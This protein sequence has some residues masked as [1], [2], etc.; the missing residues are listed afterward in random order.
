MEHM[1]NTRGTCMEYHWNTSGM[2]MEYH[3]S[4]Q[5]MYGVNV[6]GKCV[7][8]DL[9]NGSC[10]DTVWN[11]YGI[12]IE[13]GMKCKLTYLQHATCS[14]RPASLASFGCLWSAFGAPWATLRTLLTLL[15]APS[16]WASVGL[17]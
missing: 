4:T 15:G 1:W 16:L 3:P 17:L 10:M 7:E 12:C 2:P 9:T 8:C 6:N 14:P 11:M 13:L 5:N